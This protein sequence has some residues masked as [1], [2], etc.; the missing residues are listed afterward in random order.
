MAHR[1][2]SRKHLKR[3]PPCPQAVDEDAEEPNNV[4]EY[5]IMKADPDN[6]FDINTSTGEIVLKSYV[7]SM[8][9][10]Q[11]ITKQKECIWS[12]V[13]QARDQGQPSFSTT[14]VLKIDITEAVSSIVIIKPLFLQGKATESRRSFSMTP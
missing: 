3:L 13:V 7:K 12:V 10:V 8:A 11:N 6:I 4:I 2:E 9:I 14:A 5:S 1:P